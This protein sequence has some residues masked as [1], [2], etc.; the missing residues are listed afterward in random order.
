M[1][2]TRHRH[3]N[4]NVIVTFPGSL[5]LVLQVDSTNTEGY[6][7]EKYPIA[8]NL[9]YLPDSFHSV[10]KFLKQKS[11]GCT[12]YQHVIKGSLT[13]YCTNFSGGFNAL[14]NDEFPSQRSAEDWCVNI[15]VDEYV[16]VTAKMLSPERRKKYLILAVVAKIK[17]SQRRFLRLQQEQY[18][19]DNNFLTELNRSCGEFYLVLKNVIGCSPIPWYSV[20]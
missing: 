4:Q 14:A 7:R 16:S 17:W 18:L 3:Q 11:N 1:P 9:V 13:Q 8:T 20:N 12:C 2:V 5:S 10:V 15:I 19:G 6:L